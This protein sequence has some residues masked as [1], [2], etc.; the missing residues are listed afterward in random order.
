VAATKDSRLLYPDQEKRLLELAPLGIGDQ[1]DVPPETR[2]FLLVL[3]WGTG[4]SPHGP[5][6]VLKPL[7]ELTR[8]P[9]AAHEFATGADY[10]KSKDE[11]DHRRRPADGRTSSR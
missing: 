9:A 3:L 8:C 2:Q 11:S 7:F 1:L 10:E 4:H 6:G 5:R